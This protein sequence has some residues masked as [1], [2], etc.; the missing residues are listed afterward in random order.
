L[1]QVLAGISF[2]LQ[3]IPSTDREHPKELTRAMQLLDGA[4][5][6][7]RELAKGF[8][9]VELERHGLQTAL[10]DLANNVKNTYQVDCRVTTN[11]YFDSVDKNAQIHLFR[12]I[13]ESIRNAVRH[14]QAR[15]I[16]I[17]AERVGEE[18]VVSIQNEGLQFPTEKMQL[19]VA[20]SHG[21]GLKIMHY[22]ARIMGATLE[23]TP[24]RRSGCLVRCTI[25]LSK[26]P[27]P[28]VEDC[29]SESIAPDSLRPW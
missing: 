25:P 27:P 4:L 22:R 21:M 24:G 26:R 3:S 29:G 2:M 28:R 19:T 20:N 15:R 14:G 10:L 11:K 12:I 16:D 23:F 13:Q 18:V 7:T 9:P 5:S 1:G 8:Y 6:Q 17:K